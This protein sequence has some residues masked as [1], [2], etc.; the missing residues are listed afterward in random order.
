M[1]QQQA[2]THMIAYENENVAYHKHT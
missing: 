1:Q 2:K